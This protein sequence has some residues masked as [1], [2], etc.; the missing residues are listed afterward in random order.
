MSVV[1]RLEPAVM[2]ELAVAALRNARRLFDDA[3]VLRSSGR[4]ASAFTL[5]TLAGEE[6]GKHVMVM[7]FFGRDTRRDEEWDKLWRRFRRHESKLGN[8]QLGA[9]LADVYDDGDPPDPHEVHRLR[10]HATYTE[11]LDGVVS[12]P[13]DVVTEPQVAQLLSDVQGELRFAESVTGS[14]DVAK[15]TQAMV[16]QLASGGWLQSMTA[17]EVRA[18]AVSGTL[19]RQGMSVDDALRFAEMLVRRSTTEASDA[20][21][22]QVD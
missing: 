2:A 20:A 17:D 8:M 5:A 11:V 13:E 7:S 18:C 15:I 14:Q 16:G 9:W 19:V 10:L 3:L 21:G 12:C 1:A 6:V 22:S 4:L